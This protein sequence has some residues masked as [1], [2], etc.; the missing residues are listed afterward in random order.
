MRYFE[1]DEHD[2][3]FNALREC[4][5]LD[6]AKHLPQAGTNVTEE[7]GWFWKDV[8]ARL[9]RGEWQDAVTAIERR[10]EPSMGWPD[11]RQA[12]QLNGRGRRK[13]AT[14]RVAA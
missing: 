5:R 1:Y 3:L 7:A 10:F 14:G 8:G 12:E 9:G 4:R 6:V 11:A 13:R 2:T